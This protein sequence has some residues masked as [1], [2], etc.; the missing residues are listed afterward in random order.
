MN[1]DVKEHLE[2][3]GRLIRGFFYPE[4]AE[5]RIW[6][7]SAFIH[8]MFG[9]WIGL[10]VNLT[11]LGNIVMPLILPVIFGGFAGSMVW[12]ISESCWESLRKRRNPPP[13]ETFAEVSDFA[14]FPRLFYL[15]PGLVIFWALV[16]IL[17]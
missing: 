14:F 8:A 2:T 12:L 17:G 6:R 5:V 16:F 1:D 9:L 4:S 3:A 10:S 7:L 11:P 15:L 13:A